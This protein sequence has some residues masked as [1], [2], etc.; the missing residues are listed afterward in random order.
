MKA[1]YKPLQIIKLALNSSVSS[2]ASNTF[3]DMNIHHVDSVDNSSKHAADNISSSLY[4]KNYEFLSSAIPAIFHS[5]SPDVS[6]S[7]DILSNYAF[8]KDYVWFAGID[9]L[10]Y[11]SVDENEIFAASTRKPSSFSTMGSC[12]RVSYDHSIFDETLVSQVRGAMTMHL[13]Y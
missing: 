9:K 13:Y 7:Y 5:T 8:Y 2:N 12:P 1:C 11:V 10:F 6:F 3:R 4:D